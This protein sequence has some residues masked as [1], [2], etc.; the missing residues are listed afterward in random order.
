M[1]KSILKSK[2]FIAIASGIAHCALSI[3]SGAAGPAPDAWHLPSCATLAGN[4]LTVD[5]PTIEAASEGRAWTEIDI[6]EFDGHP[7]EATVEA[8]GEGISTP[9]HPWN[10]LKFQIE[11]EDPLGE[12]NYHNTESIIG[13]FGRKT[14]TTRSLTCAPRAKARLVLGLQESCGRVS[15]DLTTLRFRKGRFPWPVTNRTHK[16]EYAAAISQVGGSRQHCGVMS[17]VRDMTED[18][19]ATLASWGARLLR[20]QM[21]RP[22]PRKELDAPEEERYDPRDMEA[23]RRWLDGRLAHFADF[24]LPMCRKNGMKVVLDLHTPPGGK[25]EG[26][27]FAMFHDASL[28]DCFVDTWRRIA[29]RFAGNEDVIY[30]YDLVNEPVQNREAL[31]G[32]DYWS[33]QNRA[34]E[35]IREIDSATPIIVESNH[36]DSPGDFAVLSPLALTNIIYEVHLYAPGNYT[37]QGVRQRGAGGTWPDAASGHDKEYLRRVLKT[38]RDF[39]ERHSAKI[40][41]GEFSAIAWAPGAENYLQDCISLFGEYGW[42]WTYHAFRE[43]NA[44]SVEH[45]PARPGSGHGPLLPSADNPRKRALLEGFKCGAQPTT[46]AK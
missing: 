16:C 13:D 7:L 33:L 34:A 17:P 37:H 27:E 31:P 32:C 19:F 18:D 44:W 5:V 23:Y 43:W 15:F 42:D 21:P 9:L 28:A 10:G 3:A 4:I 2:G 6:S 40:Y 8:W 20:Y 1:P 24:V 45:E 11:F 26:S 46:T 35:A 38:V 30:G 36:Q 12:M 25:D 14:I 39:E 41:I 22:K 29:E